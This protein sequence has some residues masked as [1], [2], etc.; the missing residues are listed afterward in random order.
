VPILDRK[1][2]A[3]M[4]IAVESFTDEREV[5]FRKAMAGATDIIWGLGYEEEAMSALH[6]VIEFATIQKEAAEDR[7]DDVS[8]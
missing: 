6:D 1:K 4:P 8:E 7:R 5:M 2:G 3:E